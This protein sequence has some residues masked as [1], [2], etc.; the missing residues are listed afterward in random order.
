MASLNAQAVA[1]THIKNVLSGNIEPMKKIALKQGYSPSVANSIQ[2]IKETKS[3]KSVIEP[4]VKR[5]EKLRDKAIK[6]LDNMSI[7]DV[8]YIHLIDGIDKLTKNIQ[9]LNGGT[10]DNVALTVQIS[11]AIAKKNNIQ[12]ID[13]STP[14]DRVLTDT[15]VPTDNDSTQ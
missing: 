14:N 1:H 3:Y 9:L 7:D 2:H 8:S 15:L 10:T 12:S 6:Q 4:V 13:V 5:M 11:E